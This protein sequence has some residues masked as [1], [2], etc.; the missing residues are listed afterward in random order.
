MH[1][2]LLISEI[3]SNIFEQ[4]FTK[5]SGN[6]VLMQFGEDLDA[7]QA[8]SRL[9]VT[10]RTFT[11]PALN[12]LWRVQRVFAPL[13]RCMPRDLWTEV[14]A[15]RLTFKRALRETDW[16]RF[17]F[18]ARRIK[19]IG[20]SYLPSDEPYLPLEPSEDVFIAL[21]TYR[22]VRV[23]LPQLRVVHCTPWSTVMYKYIQAF[24][25][26]NVAHV[27]INGEDIHDED[28]NYTSISISVVDA[29]YSAVSRL[30][31]NITS[32]SVSF[33]WHILTI[34]PMFLGLLRHLR[35]LRVLTCGSEFLTD[36]P[37]DE[38]FL[39]IIGNL[40]SLEHLVMG[41]I[42]AL[43]PSRYHTRNGRFPNL[44][45]LGFVAEDLSVMGVVLQSMQCRL[46][47]FS[48]K[49][50]NEFPE[51]GAEEVVA[52][53]SLLQ[54]SLLPLSQ[55]VCRQTLL[56]FELHAEFLQFSPPTMNDPSAGDAL[57]P[58]FDCPNLRRISIRLECAI[59]LD[60]AWLADAGK[61]WPSLQELKLWSQTRHDP[62]ATF[63]GLSS[64]LR[65]CPQ[66][67]EFV[68][69]IDARILPTPPGILD[70]KNRWIQDR[71]T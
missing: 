58:L 54:Q 57:R 62:K 64:L 19:Q 44:S 31:P 50:Q 18:Y 48:A 56:S 12:V 66:L 34:D 65:G 3:L 20:E 53:L 69:R 51:Y 17:D 24:L 32:L 52:P 5:V 25:G 41:W 36:S 40:Y 55:H 30:S 71:L 35:H 26:P 7:E 8:L 38:E 6:D 68:M 59:D 70:V 9:A 28:G 46:V 49:T 45:K 29:L 67:R 1:A 22:P 13:I 39:Q 11:E 16:E 63:G 21:A 14:L 15:H 27:T 23:F 61:A 60:D 37:C 33:P 2:C 4:L 47:E 43:N 10:C 42:S